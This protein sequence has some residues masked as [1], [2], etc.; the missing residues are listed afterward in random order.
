MSHRPNIDLATALDTFVATTPSPNITLTL[1]TNLFAGPV[2]PP[3]DGIPEQCV[4][5]NHTGGALIDTFRDS[6]P[7]RV[8]SVQVRVRGNPDDFATAEALARDV[9]ARIHNLTV[10]SVAG[11]LPY[12]VVLNLDGEPNNLGQDDKEHWE[13]SIN[14]EMTYDD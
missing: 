9:W 2:R 5:V 7:T 10:T 11:A 12:M 14:V 4:F 8:A 13:F 1:D 6:A 3:G